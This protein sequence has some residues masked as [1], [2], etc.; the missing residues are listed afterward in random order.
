MEFK[1]NFQTHNT[2]PEINHETGGTYLQGHVT[3][4]YANLVSKFGE[5]MQGEDKTDAEWVLK[6]GNKVATIYNWKNGV[7]Y[8]GKEG[9]P[10]EDITEWNIGGH[11]EEVVKLVMNT[12]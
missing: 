6:F 11:S 3:V 1:M 9:T 7:N 8:C 10:T 2:N 5:P 12:V 4:T